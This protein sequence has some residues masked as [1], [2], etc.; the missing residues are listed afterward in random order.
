MEEL[1]SLI[2]ESTNPYTILENKE[3]QK[4]ILNNERARANHEQ[5]LSIYRI[6]SDRSDDLK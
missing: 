5:I 2:E 3:G 6:H 1:V 4:I